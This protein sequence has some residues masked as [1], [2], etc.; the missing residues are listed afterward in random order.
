MG[1]QV[2]TINR[3]YCEQHGYDIYPMKQM[4]CLE[5]M[6]GFSIPYLGYI[7]VKSHICQ[8]QVIAETIANHQTTWGSWP[9]THMGISVLAQRLWEWY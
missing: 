8:V 2:S 9:P 4:L 7:R 1:A 3:D 5:G 6:G